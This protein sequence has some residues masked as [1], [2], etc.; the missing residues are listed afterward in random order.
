[1]NSINQ[2]E[3]SQNSPNSFAQT[4]VKTNEVKN[5]IK[6]F[7]PEIIDTWAGKSRIKKWFSRSIKKSIVSG[8]TAVPAKGESTG[9]GAA[10]LLENPEF[11]GK[12]LEQFPS[13]INFIFS[14]GSSLFKGL[15][16]IPAKEKSLIISNIIAQ[17]EPGKTG[18][19]MTGLSKLF[20]DLH[21]NDPLFF[22]ERLTPLYIDWIQNTD[23]GELKEAL[24]NSAEDLI[25]FARMANTETWKYSSKAVTIFSFLPTIV[26]IL[27][28]SLKET[29][30]PIND[31]SPDLLTDVFLALIRDINGEELGN[32]INEIFE[33][34]RKVHT[35][36]ALLGDPG[37]PRLPREISTL[38][39]GT[40][41]T[42][43]V[44]LL[45]KGRAYFSDLK[46]KTAIACTAKL[47]NNPEL[48]KNFIK[49]YTTS[50]VRSLRTWKR[51]TETLG[52]LFSDQELSEE[53]ERA[54]S[55]IDP[56]IPAEIVNTLC[57]TANIVHAIK[58]EIAKNIFIQFFGSLDNY[59]TGE[60]VSWLTKEL[61]DAIKP[62]AGSV[63][64][65]LINGIA[66]LLNP[67]EY[68]DPGEI[69]DALLS[70]RSSVQ[71]LLVEE[72][73]SK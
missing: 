66:G 71:S 65:P 62:I 69:R 6:T 32:V 11:A 48:Q 28:G 57:V 20:N 58:P 54:L 38:L 5:I 8:F 35:G 36:S 70:L 72:E 16:Q 56:T 51:K 7:L 37:H 4:F 46:E 17:L 45:L 23:F 55:E 47:N 40:L 73:V 13:I 22:T 39:T 19:A 31:N 63:M 44:E 3:S 25:A 27:I 59:E 61:S 1:M 30:G 60:T 14:T 18:M 64:P 2:E 15:E 10:D 49:S 50:F 68:E 43:D 41:K 33:L 24:D 67:E 21:E 12:L 26:N 9:N 34:I 29:M 42:I 52:S 53:F